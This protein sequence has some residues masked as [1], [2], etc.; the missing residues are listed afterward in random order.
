MIAVYSSEPNWDYLPPFAVFAGIF[1]L[2]EMEKSFGVANMVR[3]IAHIAKLFERAIVAAHITFAA[4]IVW[5]VATTLHEHSYT[6]AQYSEALRDAFAADP[7]PIFGAVM[8]SSYGHVETFNR[9]LAQTALNYAACAFVTEYLYVALGSI[10]VTLWYMFLG[11]PL[12]TLP[13]TLVVNN[14]VGV[15][16]LK[17]LL[18]L[19]PVEQARKVRKTD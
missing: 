6:V 7:L 15:M 19:Q 11:L 10:T 14:M 5:L 9:L 17:T 12:I 2:L 18:Q 8:F 3:I 16:T 4:A 1:I 13:Y